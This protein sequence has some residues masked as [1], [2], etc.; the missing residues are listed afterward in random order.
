[1]GEGGR[2]G[3]KKNIKKPETQPE[4]VKMLKRGKKPIFVKRR[5]GGKNFMGEK[6]R[7]KD[8]TGLG[9]TRPKTSD[10]GRS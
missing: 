10:P 6:I 8:D 4:S 7:G 3:K 9:K 1:M 2:S 5:D